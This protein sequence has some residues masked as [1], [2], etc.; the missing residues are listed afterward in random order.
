MRIA[1]GGN[2]SGDPGVEIRVMIALRG[3]YEELQMSGK[4]FEPVSGN[5]RTTS[6]MTAVRDNANVESASY[7]V[8]DWDLPTLVRQH[9]GELWRYVRF[10][11]ASTNEADDL[12]QEAFLAVHRKPFEQR[13]DA[14]SAAYLRA[15][16]RRC[17]LVARR[18]E[19]RQVNAM[20]GEAAL[21]LAEAVWVERAAEER[22][23]AR[24]LALAEC[25]QSVNGRA[26]KS[27]DLFYRDQFSRAQIAEALEMKPAGVKTLLRRAREKLRD[28]VQRKV[29]T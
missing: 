17:L 2:E 26:R 15:V 29:K 28:C 6:S 27:L 3:S 7:H 22:W 24:V 13:S 5:R 19:R 9:Q 11:G 18:R 4:F 1:S 10:L 25:L 14:E 12:V 20:T 21:E 23:S 16:V 8:A